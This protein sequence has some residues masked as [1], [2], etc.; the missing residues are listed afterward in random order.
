MRCCVKTYETQH[1]K[2]CLW[3]LRP[4]LTQ[5]GLY[6]LYAHSTNF[7]TAGPQAVRNAAGFRYTYHLGNTLFPIDIM[8]KLS[9]TFKRINIF[10]CNFQRSSSNVS[11]CLRRYAAN[12]KIFKL[13]FLH[14]P[15]WLQQYITTQLKTNLI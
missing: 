10:A 15:F 14:P 13:F 4:G 11:F 5:T 6:N 8:Q 12:D 2:T 3:R 1:E 7:Q 9:C